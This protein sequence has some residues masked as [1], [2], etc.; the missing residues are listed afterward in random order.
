MSSGAPTRSAHCL[1]SPRELFPCAAFSL[2]ADLS[3]LS[4]APPRST[5]SLLSLSSPK[6]T[7]LAP[8]SLPSQ[9]S[10]PPRPTTPATPRSTLSPPRWHGGSPRATLSA[11]RVVWSRLTYPERSSRSFGTSEEITSRPFRRLVSLALVVVA[12]RLVANLFRFS[13][14]AGNRSVLIH[15][16]TKHQTQAPF[17]K[18]KGEVQRVSFHPSRPHFFVAVSCFAPRYLRTHL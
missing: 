2:G 7:P 11:R 1:L 16:L 14:T 8:L 12:V 5:S 18:Q 9:D 15:Q 3:V 13:D 6:S 4:S 10:P 17:T